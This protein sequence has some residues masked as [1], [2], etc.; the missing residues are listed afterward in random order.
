[1]KEKPDG[2]VQGPKASSKSHPSLIQLDLNRFIPKIFGEMIE[3]GLHG[4]FPRELVF[5]TIHI[6]RSTSINDDT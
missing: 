4:E 3:K 2:E 5:M 1:M 6:D